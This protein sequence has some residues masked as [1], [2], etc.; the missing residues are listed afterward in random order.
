[1]VKIDLHIHSNSYSPCSRISPDELAAMAPFTGLDGL[2][3][4]EHN[5]QWTPSEKEELQEKLGGIK[6]YCAME[7]SVAEG[8]FLVIGADLSPW[9]QSKTLA[10]LAVLASEQE[11]AL[12]WAHPGRFTPIPDN[13][14]EREDFRAIHGIEVMSSN[15]KAKHREG[16]ARVLEVL[17]KP[18]LAGSDSHSPLTLGTYATM[19]PTLPKDEKE[20]AQMIKAPCGVPW[21]N[22][23][24]LIPLNGKPGPEEEKM[25][26][27]P[28]APFRV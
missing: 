15:I 1:M 4:T 10:D 3:I 21:A 14:S 11:A 25:L 18:T 23:K 7:A 24:A 5:F 27:T 13:L 26:L 6:L 2:V 8:H 19:F 28:P 16:I 22:R 9:D 17:K 20:L 12:I